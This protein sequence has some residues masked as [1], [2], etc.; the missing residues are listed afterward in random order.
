MTDIT[1][2]ALNKL[3]IDYSMVIDVFAAFEKPI[4]LFSGGKDSIVLAHL[5]EPLK[6]YFYLVWVNTG[7]ALPHM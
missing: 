1:S 7:A 2:T 3:E 4:V 5:L 6:D